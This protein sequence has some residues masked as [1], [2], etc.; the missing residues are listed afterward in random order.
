MEVR[1][2]RSKGSSTS[3]S[4]SPTKRGSRKSSSEKVDRT[5]TLAIV[6]LLL[7]L[8]GLVVALAFFPRH[9]PRPVVRGVD[10][11][12]GALGLQQRRHAVV[13]DAGSTGSRVLA[14]TF[15][16]GLLDG[17]LHLEDELWREVKPGLSAHADRPEVAAQ[18][19][20]K[21][22]EEARTRVPEAQRA[23]TPL[24]LKATA[25]LRLLPEVK[26]K[27]VLDEVERTLRASG[28]HPEEKLIEIMDPT[29]EGVFG[30][31]TVNFLTQRLSAGGELDDS[32]AT[33]DLGGGSTQITFAP[34]ERPLLGLQGRKNF[35]HDVTVMGDSVKLYS[36]SYLGL[37]LMAAREAI[38]KSGNP[39]DAANKLKSPC[40]TSPQPLPWKYQG[41]EY[42]VFNDGASFENCIKL[43][44]RVVNGANVHMPQ[45]LADKEIAAFSYFY[46]RASEIG[47]VPPGATEGVVT[48]RSFIYEAGRACD[49]D[50]NPNSGF[51]CVDLAFISSLLTK[52]YGLPQEKEITLFKKVDGHEASWALGLAYNTLERA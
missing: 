37:G 42:L 1:K 21:L 11:A 14:F 15:S 30:W 26:A 7:L 38:F 2:R 24:V 32:F 10:T 46:D 5:C 3:G 43:V 28:F 22:L 27:A 50:A 47:L 16:R 25:G 44:N 9:V 51:Y 49:P 13:I 45:P 52:G 29:E 40:V 18:S 4:S 34:G 23:S 36:H 6:L 31:F 33:L 12:L 41:K 19:V 20:E 17:L 35:M 8:V 39:G 48:V